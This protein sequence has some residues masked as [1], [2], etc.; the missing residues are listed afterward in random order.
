MND[1]IAVAVAASHHDMTMNYTAFDVETMP[2][3]LVDPHPC[4]PLLQNTA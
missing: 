4:R 1:H 2:Y 3:F